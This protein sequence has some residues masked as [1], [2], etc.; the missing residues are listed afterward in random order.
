MELG[1]VEYQPACGP[2]CVVPQR[3]EV[4]GRGEVWQVPC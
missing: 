4:K 3:V 2:G 1:G